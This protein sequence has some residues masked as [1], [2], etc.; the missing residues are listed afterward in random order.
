M[1]EKTR[2]IELVGILNKA[3]HE[4]YILDNPTLTD[5]EYET[6]WIF[7]GRFDVS[8]AWILWRWCR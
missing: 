4:Y 7:Y 3:N 2:I 1:K 8:V 6:G 5:R